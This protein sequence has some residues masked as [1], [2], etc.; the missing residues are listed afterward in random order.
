MGNVIVMNEAQMEESVSLIGRS[1]NNQETTANNF[2]TKMSPI[3][4]TGLIDNA[5]DTVQDQMDSL[6]GALL[7]VKNI[8]QKHSTQMFEMDRQLSK[9]ASN[10]EIPQD[11]VKNDTMKT[12]SFDQ[13][14][15]EKMDG[16]SVNDGSNLRDTKPLDE[17]S[18]AGV[19]LGNIKNGNK[20]DEQTY[21]ETMTVQ[22]E[23]L[24]TISKNSNL[25]EKKLD[26]ST[27]ISSVAVKNI[28]KNE[29][30]DSKELNDASNI[31]RTNLQ[32]LNNDK[33]II[34]DNPNILTEKV[35]SGIESAKSTLNNALNSSVTPSKPLNNNVSN[36]ASVANISADILS[37]NKNL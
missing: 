13:M 32:Q 7:N 24:N 3:K 30:F 17:S 10:I 29:T 19:N 27:G 4:N 21:D 18:V 31:V 22:K 20:N 33:Q 14:L 11:F 35:L 12:N 6:S 28:N 15:I 37:N 8:V 2:N 36:V 5:I 1:Q 25:D 16:Q 9:I 34:E 26:D 23:N